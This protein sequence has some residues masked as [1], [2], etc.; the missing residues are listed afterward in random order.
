MSSASPRRP[1]YDAELL[2]GVSAIPIPAFSAE[3]LQAARDWFPTNADHL[4]ADGTI[5]HTQRIF[6]GPESDL[7]ISIFRPTNS[8]S[9]SHSPR[10]CFYS[11]H[12]GGMIVGNRFAINGG[13]L[14]W[15]KEFDAICVSIEYRLAPDHP[16]PAPIEDSYAGLLYTHEHAADLGIDPSK[17][18]LVGESAGGGLAAGLSLLARDRHGPK[19]LGQ[20][21]IAPML[22]DRDLHYVS[23]HQLADALVWNLSNNENG[24]TSLLGKRAG[25]N[26]VSCYAAPGRAEDLSGLS[27]VYIDVGSAEL[28]RD[29]DISFSSRLLEYGVQVEL[30]V[31]PGAF[32]WSDAMVPTHPLSK[33]AMATRT[34]WLRRLLKTDS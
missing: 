6:K 3:N 13:I 30:H 24:W 27:P 2:A 19:P 1:P 21:L 34:E 26:N 32:H 10:P 31:W 23:R 20:L 18:I 15:L 22:D 12:G 11:T 29:E 28:F 9:P 8:K 33:H 17:I 25:G 5:E 4:T 7:T 16:D 14:V